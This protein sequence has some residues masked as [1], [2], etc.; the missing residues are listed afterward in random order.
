LATRAPD[1]V[2]PA[3]L[4]PG[5]PGHVIRYRRPARLFHAAIYLVTFV[6]LGTGWWLRTGHEGE[7]S[8]LA[9][10]IDVADVEIHRQAGWL[11]VAVVT[12]GMTLGF[13]GAFTFVRETLRFNRGD[14]T[15][16]RRWPFGAFT[17]KFV[18]H[19][20][21]FDPGQ[22]IVNVAFVATIGTLVVTGVGLTTVHGGSQF[23]ALSRVHRGST[24]FL[25]VLIV[26]HVII[27]IGVLPGY[28]GAWRSMHGRGKTP[29]ET[30][31][32]LWPASL[33]SQ[34]SGE[35]P[36]CE[37]HRAHSTIDDARHSRAASG[38]L[39]GDTHR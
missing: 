20:G 6:L 33:D 10:T 25:T 36:R 12:V 7:P 15:W 21:H 2:D 22:R 11:L 23:V 3:R 16:F 34:K 14:G 31:R 29:V 38:S 13:R 4:P 18:P 19:K 37:P 28:R 35:S 1:R 32:R 39:E 26:A 8:L 9:R 17:G 5:G 24:Y 30:A 27:A